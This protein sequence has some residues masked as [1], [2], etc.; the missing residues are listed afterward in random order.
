MEGTKRKLKDEDT[1]ERKRGRAETIRTADFLSDLPNEILAQIYKNMTFGCD[2]RALF[3]LACSKKARKVFFQEEQRIMRDVTEK[4]EERRSKLE[5]TVVRQIKDRWANFLIKWL[6]IKEGAIMDIQDPLCCGMTDIE[7]VLTECFKSHS[8]VAFRFFII[9]QEGDTLNVCLNI[10]RKNRFLAIKVENVKRMQILASFV[11][12]FTSHIPLDI[13]QLL[14]GIAMHNKEMDSGLLLGCMYRHISRRANNVDEE[15]VIFTYI[16]KIIFY[17]IELEKNRLKEFERLLLMYSSKISS[18]LESSPIIRKRY[19]V[20][21]YHSHFSTE[22]DY[23]VAEIWLRYVHIPSSY[24]KT[25]LTSRRYH[26]RFFLE[27]AYKH[28]P[29]NTLKSIVEYAWNC[30]EQN[31]HDLCN[32]WDFAMKKKIF[33]SQQ[34]EDITRPLVSRSVSP[35]NQMMGLKTTLSIFDSPF[36]VTNEMIGKLFSSFVDR[37]QT[38]H[39]SSRLLGLITD[40]VR[41]GRCRLEDTQIKELLVLAAK[42]TLPEFNELLFLIL[43]MIPSL[44][45]EFFDSVV[46]ELLDFANGDEERSII[47]PFFIFGCISNGFVAGLLEEDRLFFIPFGSYEQGRKDPF[48]RRY[49]P[50]RYEQPS[51]ERLQYLFTRGEYTQQILKNGELNKVMQN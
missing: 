33:T 10:M 44:G 23:L 25:L 36:S 13:V 28:Q 6:E 17:G 11:S 39:E 19:G 7:T 43:R 24:I 20:S 34:I 21:M 26:W 51:P 22:E 12:C 42:R 9:K 14:F 47:I 16:S 2:E 49:I 37:E 15:V 4:E 46:R 45:Q 29:E 41:D 30:G 18:M 1:E 8:P 27:I 40:F 31:A 3:T 50:P 35:K 5:N 32:V 38:P 48:F